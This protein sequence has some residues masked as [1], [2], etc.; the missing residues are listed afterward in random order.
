MRRIR[1]VLRLRAAL[2]QNISAIAS[3]ASMSRSTVREYLRRA[4]AAK[5]DAAAA[6]GLTD[7][8][9]EVALFPPVDAGK[10][11]LPD[12]A[13][14]DEELRRDKHVTR[15]LLWVEYK[16]EHPDGYEFSQFK[17]LLS[18]WQEESGRGLSMRQVHRAG[19]AVQVDYAGDTVTVIDRGVERQAQIFV[20]C[21]PC[22]SLVYAEAT[23]TQGH[24]DW[25]AAHVR[26]FAFLGGVP[27]KIIP[28]N[29]KVGVTHAS[30][31][32][33]V[34]NASYAALIKHYETVVLPAR[35]RKPKDKPSVEGSV[36]QVYRWMF[37]P[38]RNRQFFSL[39]EL[40]EALKERLTALND[41]P[42]APPR[43]GS[44]RSLFEAVERAALKQ[45][46]AEPYVI[47]EWKIGL[48]V[49]VDYH[50]AIERNCYSVPYTLVRKVVDAFLTPTSVQIFHRSERIAIHPRLVGQNGY[51]TQ[52]MHLAP[53]HAAVANRTPDWLRG[54]AAKIGVATAEYVE[55]L[56]TGRAHVEQGIRSCLG[57]L[58]MAGKYPAARM[59]SACHRALAAGAR[60]SG[61]IEELLKSD[62]PIPEAVSDD[63]AG[64][65]SNIRGPGY[66]N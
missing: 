2:G 3:G 66:Y 24:E 28:D 32:D 11:P 9:L 64:H 39:V 25:L 49:N 42:M 4:A 40:N 17:R 46:P 20:A 7:E 58:R 52:E 21:L 29:L 13:K 5:I 18:A 33:P 61:Y 23:W 31:Y 47:G 6:G 55:R 22:S 63:G 27:E 15:M 35:V 48:T 38:L 8:A 16:T 59:E 19:A 62:R 14:V 1:E 56:L 45:L 26:L 10:R 41:K 50:I 54:E 43:E 12:W 51:S 65:H 30:Y 37:A 36:L 60:S 57:I 53:A 34:I 44:R